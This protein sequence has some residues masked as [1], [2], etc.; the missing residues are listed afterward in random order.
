M[1]N[2]S[3]VAN[4]QFKARN[5][6]D[7]IR[8][9]AMYTQE[10]RAQEDAIADL[11]T[12]ADVWA[13]LANEQ[14][15]PVAYAQYT[16]YANALKDQAAVMADRGLNPSSRQ[17]MLNLKRRYSSEI[18]PIEQAY[19]ARKA[20]AEEQRKALLQNPTLMMSRRADTTSLDRYMENPNLGYE[21]YSGAL[22]TQQVGQ[23]ASAIAK[24][25]RDYGKGKPLDGFTKTW[26]QE[27][28][29]RDNEVN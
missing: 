9:Y 10:Y 24:E 25:L 14:T 3:L 12:K 22:L 20:Q 27:H 18:V 23:A 7:M 21:S 8:P 11:A 15:D 2:Y 6:D 29:Y 19:T 4:T 17:T 5:F 16:N 1:P 13:G 26:L 28:G